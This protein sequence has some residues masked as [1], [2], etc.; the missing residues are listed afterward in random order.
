MNDSIRGKTNSEASHGAS[1]EIEKLCVL[2]ETL[3]GWIDEI[4]P[5]QQPQRFG[6]Q[7][8]KVWYNRLKDVSFIFKNYNVGCQLQVVV[9]MLG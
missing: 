9:Y 6:N 1:P 2:L 5:V 3:N 8:F 7:A 4:P